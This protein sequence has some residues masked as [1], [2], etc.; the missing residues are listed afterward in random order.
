MSRRS[1]TTGKELLSLGKAL[2]EVKRQLAYPGTFDQY[3]I[4]IDLNP[5]WA[6]RLIRIVTAFEDSVW[7]DEI[8]EWPLTSLSVMINKHGSEA[9]DNVSQWGPRA[10]PPKRQGHYPYILAFRD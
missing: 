8:L 4:S 6:K 5:R 3:L 2:I 10:L 7:A 9:I 1:P